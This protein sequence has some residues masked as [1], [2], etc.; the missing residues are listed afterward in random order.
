MESDCAINRP[1]TFIPTLNRH[2]CGNETVQSRPDSSMACAACPHRKPA[3]AVNCMQLWCYPSLCMSANAALTLVGCASDLAGS[4]SRCAR[5]QPGATM[6]CACAWS[7][8]D[9]D[10]P[11]VSSCMRHVHTTGYRALSLYASLLP[12]RSGSHHLV[13]HP[14]CCMHI[15]RCPV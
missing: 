2:E 5:P 12:P 4:L 9:D 10:M 8:L 14:T 15:G 7:T 3:C 6:T 1:V 13:S 11:H